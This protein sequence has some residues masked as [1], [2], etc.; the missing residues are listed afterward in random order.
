MENE[1]EQFINQIKVPKPHLDI[2]KSRIMKEW[3]ETKNMK[4]KGLPQIQ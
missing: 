1:F 3:E 4:E 2:F